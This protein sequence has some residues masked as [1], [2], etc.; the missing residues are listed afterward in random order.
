MTVHTIHAR[1]AD[2]SERESLRQMLMIER[3][4]QK[5]AMAYQQGQQ[6][7]PL[8]GMTGLQARELPGTPDHIEF[9]VNQRMEDIKQEVD[10]LDREVGSLNARRQLLEMEMAVLLRVASVINDSNTPVPGINGPRIFPEGI[11]GGPSS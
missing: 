9:E 11:G 4:A 6:S 1:T 3:D 5:K 8:P 10:V 2:E 7:A